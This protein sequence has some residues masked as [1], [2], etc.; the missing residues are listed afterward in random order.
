MSADPTSKL[1]YD[2]VE[3][4]LWADLAN[5]LRRLEEYGLDPIAALCQQL[6]SAPVAVL[7]AGDVIHGGGARPP[8]GYLLRDST[9]SWTVAD[10]AKSATEQTS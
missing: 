7:D 6:G 2:A 9:A 3:Y 4:A 5:A 1:M 10:R 8:G